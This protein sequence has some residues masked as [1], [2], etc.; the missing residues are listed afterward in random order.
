MS[1]HA[2]DSFPSTDPLCRIV[3]RSR[4]CGDPLSN[5]SAITPVRGSSSSVK[6]F[7][8]LSAAPF[9]PRHFLSGDRY[10]VGAPKNARSALCC[11]LMDVSECSFRDISHLAL[12]LE[13]TGYSDIQNSVTHIL[14]NRGSVL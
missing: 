7:R 5:C 9:F 13:S 12:A 14:P 4:Q 6:V 2:C 10:A 11:S 1:W 8:P 3:P